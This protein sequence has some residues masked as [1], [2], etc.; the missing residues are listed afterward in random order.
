M[1]PVLLRVAA[2]GGDCSNHAVPNS[3]IPLRTFLAESGRK[4]QKGRMPYIR[5]GGFYSEDSRTFAS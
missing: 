2:Q 4:G 1:Q 3:A 5:A